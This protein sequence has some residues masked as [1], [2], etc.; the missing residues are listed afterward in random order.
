VNYSTCAKKCSSLTRWLPLLAVISL[1]A[2]KQDATRVY[3]T[4]KENAAPATAEMTTPD[5]TGGMA[6][7]GMGGA[8]PAGHPDMGA[9]AQP[10]LTWKTPEGWTE[11]PPGEM[12]L[13]SF[14]VK[15]KNGKQADVSI[16]PLPGM[17]GGD[18]ANVN[19]WRSQVGLQPLS[20]EELQK[21]AQPV[22]VAGQPGELYEQVGKNPGSGEGMTILAVIQH[23]EGTAWFFK[24]TG[25]PEVVAQQKPA[26]VE[27]LK[28]V[29]F[30]TAAALPPS[31]PP[32]EGTSLP[33]GHPDISMTPAPTSG[34]I[35]TEGKPNWQTPAGWQEVSGGQF[36]AA[37]FMIAGEAGAQAAVNVSSSAGDGGG[38]AANVNRWRKQLGLAELSNDELGKSVS[39]IDVAGGKATLVEMSGTNPTTGQPARLVGAMVTQAGQTWFYKLMGDAKVVEAQKAAF[40][41][42]VQTVKY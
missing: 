33:T 21:L 6:Q 35:S 34:P 3:Y 14:N 37:K 2:C 26:L 18:S 36:L 13:A 1:T 12:R 28:S 7:S 11:V 38:L 16:V 19:R 23:R 10:Q 5:N 9:T 29:Q 32:I 22:V 41:K 15:S 8:L 30:Q 24:M 27:F 17:A 4:A 40:A 25:D 42:F 31:H 20:A 39:S